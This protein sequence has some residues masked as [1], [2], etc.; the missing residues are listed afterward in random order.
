M[1][2]Q[3]PA[4]SALPERLALVAVLM[5]VGAGWGLA[6][7]LTK[8]A[9]SDGYRQFGLIFWQLVIT[10]ALLS[11]LTLLRGKRLPITSR[12]LRF[13]LLIACIGT[14][15]PNSAS[16]A[17]AVHLPGGVLAIM[18][19]TVPLFAFPVAIALGNDRFEWVRALGLLF[20]LACVVLIMA[21]DASL[22]GAAMA[23]F[24]PLALVAPLFYG[25]EGNVL[26]RWGTR[27]LDP[28]Q[29]L[30]GAS[31][32][33][34][35]IALVMALAS[36]QFIDPRGPW[37]T[38]DYALVGTSVIHAIVYASYFWLVGRAGPT[39]AAQ[40]SYPVTGF[41]VAWSI[42][43]LSESYSPYVW[44]GLGLMLVGIFLVQPRPR[45]GLAEGA[46]MGKYEARSQQ[47]PMN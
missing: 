22:P 8:L 31:L 46:R 7:P 23:A 20:G 45:I 9:V 27:G 18:L 42:V 39:F 38:P 25:L 12:H 10:G 36:G 40:V 21:P 6:T 37:A 14:V 35:P 5:L 26:A 28:I 33:G 41:G 11:A 43:L 13:Y 4:S 2:L 44:A 32:T 29:V 34:A 16:Y 1:S 30:A 15:I 17:S 19:S 47:D 3:A 24:I